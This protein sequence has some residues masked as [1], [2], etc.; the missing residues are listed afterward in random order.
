MQ[1][2]QVRSF[3]WSHTGRWRAPATP[4]VETLA[5]SARPGAM[6]ADAK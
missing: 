1:G 2:A 6:P 5:A 4:A 3:R